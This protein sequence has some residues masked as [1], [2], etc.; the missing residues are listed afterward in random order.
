MKT[1]VPSF[2]PIGYI[3]FHFVASLGCFLFFITSP[4]PIKWKVNV[5]LKST[6][7]MFVKHIFHFRLLMWHFRFCICVNIDGKNKTSH[8]G[9]VAITRPIF[10][11][12]WGLWALT[13][14]LLT[15]HFSGVGEG[16]FKTPAE[17]GRVAAWLI[18]ENILCHL[19][20]FFCTLI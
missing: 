14:S 6:M 9:N 4:A 20:P 13:L 5:S 15:H 18:P 2:P 19:L 8:A 3:G 16:A 10:R 1:I 17:T 12:F 11:L 7:D